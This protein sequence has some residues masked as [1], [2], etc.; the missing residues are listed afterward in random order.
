MRTSG[1]T[2]VGVPLCR[3]AGC[4]LPSRSEPGFCTPCADVQGAA[5]ALR[6]TLLARRAAR[7][8]AQDPDFF[9]EL[10]APVRG[11]LLS[12]I[13]AQRDPLEHG[14]DCLAG[15]EDFLADLVE[16]GLARARAGEA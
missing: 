11:R 16:L 4:E 15:L 6:E 9:S 7:V 1:L 8:Q 10:S 13:A 12:H 2:A 3:N 5:Q 14:V